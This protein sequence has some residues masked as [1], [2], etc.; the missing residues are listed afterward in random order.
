MENFYFGTCIWKTI[1][2]KIK[3]QLKLLLFSRFVFSDM[4]CVQLLTESE[5]LTSEI[6]NF[7]S[8]S[9]DVGEYEANVLRQYL[10]LRAFMAD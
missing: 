8:G 4:M 5:P 3:K 9:R 1:W 10:F 6:D 7:N 2:N